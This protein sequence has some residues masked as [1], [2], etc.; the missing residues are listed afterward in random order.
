MIS[1]LH[2]VTD[3]IPVGMISAS[4]MIYASRIGER[5]LYHA[6]IASISCGISRISYCVSNISLLWFLVG[7]STLLISSE[8]CEDFI[9]IG[10]F[11]L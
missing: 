10:Q 5:I 11:H 1:V 9:A 8:L 3:D 6:C 7:L 2:A 4:Q